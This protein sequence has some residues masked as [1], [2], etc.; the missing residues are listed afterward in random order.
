MRRLDHWVRP[1]PVDVVTIAEAPW[2]DDRV[3]TASDARVVISGKWLAAARDRASS[4][5]LVVGLSKL[6]W[7]GG[8]ASGVVSSGVRDYV[9]TRVIHDQFSGNHYFAVD[10]L[11]GFATHA[12]RPVTLTRNAHDERP[13]VRRFPETSPDP[14]VRRIVDALFTLERYIGWP[15]LQYGI[16]EW[17]SSDAPTDD[18]ASLTASL[19]RASGRDLQWFTTAGFAAARQFDYA[20]RDLT[21]GEDVDGWRDVTV[22]VGRF[23]DAVFPVD[24]EVVFSDGTRVRER[25]DGHAANNTYRYRSRSEAVAAVVDPDL[26]LLLD[27]DRRNNARVLRAPTHIAGVRWT[28]Q[29]ATWL[30]NVVMTAAALI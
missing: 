1:S 7:N 30:Q 20:I 11:G 14:A 17:L 26:V 22:T 6:Y 4:R 28:M 3:A 10:L 12:V 9:A 21:N 13:P 8:T 18:V 2:Y 29:W 15:T 19:E 23:G 27:A 25:W 24:V 16:T 5:S